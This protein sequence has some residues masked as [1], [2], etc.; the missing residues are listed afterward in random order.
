[1]IRVAGPLLDQIKKKN[2]ASLAAV[3]C[4][5]ADSDYENSIFNYGLP[6]PVRHLI[7]ASIG[8]ETTYSD[9]IAFL[10]RDLTRGVRYLEIGVSVG[11]NF[12]QMLNQWSEALLVGFDIEDINP[13]LERHLEK[14]ERV[15]W[16]TNPG[17][18]RKAP[19]SLA[20]YAFPQNGNR[21][22]YLAGDVFDEQSWARLTG[23]SFNLVFSDAYHSADALLAEWQMIKSLQRL[24]AE[25]FIFVWDD[26]GGEMGQAFNRISG[27]MR[28]MFRISASETWLGPCR[29]WLGTNE[30]YHA[31]GVVR[32]IRAT[33]SR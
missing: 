11:K 17:S 5:I 6:A 12:F 33:A 30:G 4:W 21:V 13:V 27:E 1:M 8:D 15:V 23:T 18:L 3:K 7:D 28:E 19:S 29:G 32:K 24:D 14:G 25:E 10:A 26:L 2:R 22:R 9:L 31:V 20:N 16:E